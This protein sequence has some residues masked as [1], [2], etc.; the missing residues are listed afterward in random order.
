M[1]VRYAMER[2]KGGKDPAKPISLGRHQNCCKICNHP[3]QEEIQ[4][5][6]LNWRSP[7]AIAKDYGLADRTNISDSR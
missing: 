5:D 1:R 6:F 2:E 7:S 4:R 3:A